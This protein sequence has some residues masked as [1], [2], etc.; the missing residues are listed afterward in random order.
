MGLLSWPL[1]LKCDLSAHY[2]CYRVWIP[3]TNS[4]RAS[5]TLDNMPGLSRS[6]LRFRT[7]LASMRDTPSALRD[8]RQ[9]VDAVETRLVQDM[10]ALRDM[11]YPEQP[12]PVTGAP[13]APP[14]GAPIAMPLAPVAPAAPE[15]LHIPSHFRGWP[16]DLTS[17][18]PR[19]SPGPRQ[20]T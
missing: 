20:G 8:S 18:S 12:V 4:K 19:S 16:Y 15:P 2:R 14:A 13:V 10:L 3:E 11:Y 5:A 17:L 6:E 1:R 9:P 7:I